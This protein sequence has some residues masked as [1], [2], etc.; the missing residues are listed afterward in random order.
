[1]KHY[2]LT[3]LISPE[4]SEETV[5]AFQEKVIV[6]I[7]DEGGN[8]EEVKTPLIK[9]LAYSLKKPDLPT[10]HDKAYLGVLNFQLNPEKIADLEK[11]LKAESQILRYLLLNKPAVKKLGY[12]PRRT[13]LKSLVEK[14]KI[15]PEEKK[16]ELKEIEKK[17]EEILNEPSNEPQ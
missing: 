13:P 17:L 3:Y 9:K 16:V 6:L 7:K 14:P 11:K 10:K 5:L 12:A 15:V 2:E 4:L 1:M 8:L